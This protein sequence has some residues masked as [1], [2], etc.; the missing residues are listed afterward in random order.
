MSDTDGGVQAGASRVFV[1][2]EVG[3]SST[4]RATRAASSR[5]VRGPLD[6]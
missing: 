3:G 2:R 4:L 5:Q 1:P 6:M